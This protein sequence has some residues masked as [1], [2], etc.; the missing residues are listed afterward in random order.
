[1]H[2][3]HARNPK[4]PVSH[5]RGPQALDPV[6]EARRLV[7]TTVAGDQIKLSQDKDEAEHEF[8]ALL[9]SDNVKPEPSLA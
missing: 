1:M 3:I 5:S 9:T 8:H 7:Y 4:S 2:T 6:S